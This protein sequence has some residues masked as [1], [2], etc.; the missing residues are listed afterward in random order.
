MLNGVLRRQITFYDAKQ[1]ILIHIPFVWCVIFINILDIVTK[2][3][4]NVT[5]FLVFAVTERQFIFVTTINV[6]TTVYVTKIAL[7]PNKKRRG[8]FVGKRYCL[9]CKSQKQ[10]LLIL[11]CKITSLICGISVTAGA[12]VV[13]FK[14][15]SVTSVTAISV[16]VVT[17]VQFSLEKQES[18]VV[19]VETNNINK[20]IA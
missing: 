1:S 3:R 16:V 2:S 15:L 8:C 17:V 11:C 6:T 14:S 5:I 10:P 20:T 18:S 13:T 7:Q 4:I 19:V 12:T 9:T